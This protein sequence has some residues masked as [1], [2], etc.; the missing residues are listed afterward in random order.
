MKTTFITALLGLALFFSCETS[1]NSKKDKRDESLLIIINDIS[2][3]TDEFLIFSESHIKTLLRQL[4]EN[5]GAKVY[6][7]LIKSNSNKQEPI[8]AI[9]PIMNTINGRGSNRIMKAKIQRHNEDVLNSFES[10]IQTSS[11]ELCNGLLVP[12]DED[13]TD[14]NGALEIVNLILDQSHAEDKKVLILS[15]MI[16]DLPGGKDVDPISTSINDSEAE[17]LFVR[18]NNDVDLPSLFPSNQIKKFSSI[19]D[20]IEVIK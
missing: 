3:S 19:A 5:G 16:N 1:T 20:A 10:E 9:V 8:R 2:K 7:L 6:G 17:L 18:P 11:R 15:D 13:Y 12:K 4:G 14:I